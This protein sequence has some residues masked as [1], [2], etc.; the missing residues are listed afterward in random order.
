MD[1]VSSS[2]VG[3][4]VQSKEFPYF[5]I[6]SQNIECQPKGEGTTSARHQHRPFN[7]NCQ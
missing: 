1:A 4:V 6:G 7:S 5:S 2:N 3:P